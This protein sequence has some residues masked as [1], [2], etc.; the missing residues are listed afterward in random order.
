MVKDTILYDVLGVAPE[1]T[2]IE[3]VARLCS[4]V[5]TDFVQQVE[6]GLQEKG[7]SGRR[8]IAEI[9]RLFSRVPL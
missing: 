3:Y 7:Y 2:D 5:E 8:N 9:W 1:A 6:E 4:L